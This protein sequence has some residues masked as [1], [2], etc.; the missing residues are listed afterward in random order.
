MTY[1]RMFEILSQLDIPKFIHYNFFSRKVHRDR[2]CFFLP[3]RGSVIQLKKNASIM[4]HANYMLCGARLK[5][6]KAEAQLLIRENGKL[7]VNGLI[8]QMYGSTIQVH[9]NAVMTTGVVTLNTGAVVISA[10]QLN[11]GN[12]VYISRDVYVFDSD[13]HKILDEE[14]KQTNLPKPTYIGDHVWIG[15]GSKIL[16][17]AK[18]G[19]GAVIAAGSVV[20]GKLHPNMLALGYPARSY[21]SVYWE[22]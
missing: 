13:H 11:I 1:K 6:S 15:I 20:M 9:T 10:G 2:G 16:R 3:Y 7:I 21:S 5:G 4:L 17:G 8:F 19:D 14:G 12:E 18:I 22:A